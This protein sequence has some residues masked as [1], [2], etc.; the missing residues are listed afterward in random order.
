MAISSIVSRQ[1]D[2]KPGQITSSR[3]TPCFF[4]KVEN[5]ACVEGSIHLFLPKRLWNDTT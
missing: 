2:T 1:S 5:S 4:G 3:R